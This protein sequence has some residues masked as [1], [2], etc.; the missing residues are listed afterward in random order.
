MS[1]KKYRRRQW[2]HQRILIPSFLQ[3]WHQIYSYVLSTGFFKRSAISRH[4]KKKNIDK[5]DIARVTSF[6]LQ[7]DFNMS[8][9]TLKTAFSKIKSE[10]LSNL[11]FSFFLFKLTDSEKRKKLS[12]KKH[13]GHIGI[14]ANRSKLRSKVLQIV[15]RQ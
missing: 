12:R 3:T 2:R 14:D 9:Y 1:N 7:F 5:Q 4:P 11:N 10:A 8:D 13:I 6:F 15:V